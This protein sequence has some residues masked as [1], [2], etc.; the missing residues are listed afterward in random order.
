MFDFEIFSKREWAA[1]I[2]AFA[3]VTALSLYGFFRLLDY[4]TTSL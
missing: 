2:V 4:L 3:A 1:M